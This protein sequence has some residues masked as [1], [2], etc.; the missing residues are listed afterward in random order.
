MALVVLY[1]ARP[2]SGRVL[3]TPMKL[4]V[5][6][7]IH[8]DTRKLRRAISLLQEHGAET[9]VV[10]GDVFDMG[11]RLEETVRILQDIKAVGVWGNHD[12]GLCFD[13]S[14]GVCAR[15][16]T[17][18]LEF[19]SALQPHLE[20]DGCLFTHIE[21]WLDPY[22]I[23]DLWGCHG[24]PDSPEKL[25]R[26]FAASPHRVMFMG[27]LHRWLVGTPEGVLPWR[28]EQALRLDANQ[29]YLVV[30]HAV[31]NGRCALFDTGS[32]ELVPFGEA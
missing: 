27:H 22:E 25:A 13:P 18:V 28:G 10:L 24:A 9:F 5:L 20:I 6:A 17:R 15:Y 30:V 19:M 1:G 32:G 2:D 3:I 23:E 11:P 16:S 26:N 7:D 12:I 29:R 4:G 14:E 21:P 8:E 31:W